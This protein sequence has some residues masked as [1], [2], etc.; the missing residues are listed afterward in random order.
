MIKFSDK[1]LN[2]QARW[3]TGEQ[4]RVGIAEYELKREYREAVEAQQKIEMAKPK[5]QRDRE[6]RNEKF[7]RWFSWS[8]KQDSAE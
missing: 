8:L 2:L 1:T 7:D 3:F 4:W 5:A 6:R